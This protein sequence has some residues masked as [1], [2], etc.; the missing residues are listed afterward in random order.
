M[1]ELDT[2]IEYSLKLT[3]IAF[4]MLNRIRDRR[5]REG[6]IQ[7]I[8]KLKVDPEKQGKPLTDKLKGYRSVRA[9]GQQYR[10]IYR[11]DCDR[12]VVFVVGVGLRK[13]GDSERY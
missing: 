6:L 8:A 13:Q 2:S 4:E 3:P 11:V 12:I 1:T 7:R 10:I 5:H 9:M